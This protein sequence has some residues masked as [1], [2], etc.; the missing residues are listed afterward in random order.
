ME[1]SCIIGIIKIFFVMV[2]SDNA[3][4][5][6]SLSHVFYIMNSLSEIPNFGTRILSVITTFSAH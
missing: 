6:L 2:D 5:S 4:D 1:D 3:V